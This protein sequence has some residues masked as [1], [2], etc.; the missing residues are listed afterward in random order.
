LPTLTTCEGN[1]V[2]I[3]GQTTDVPGIYTL[4]L[5]NINGCDSIISQ[6]LKV[7]PTTIEETVAFCEGTSKTVFDSTFT[8]TGVICKTEVS[9]ITG[10][11]VTTCVT[12]KEVPS[13]QVPEQDSALVIALNGEVV[14]DT[15]NDYATYEWI[16]FNPDILSCPDC[17]DPVAS[18][19]TSTK[20][21]L[22]ITD[23]NGCR[24]TAEYRVFVCD[25]TKIY[26]PNAFTPN[27]DGANDLFRVVPHEGADVILSLRV[28][29]R[30]GQKLYE[31]SGPNAQWDGRI[32]D[33]LAPSDVYVWVLDYEC[34]GERHRESK[35]VTLL[36]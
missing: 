23:G 1:P 31:G 14:I 5:Q 20:F 12:V 10:C 34:G 26:I 36:R 19:D 32:G 24:D 22:V 27:G 28:Y 18:P 15:P 3:L 33:K 6:E 13:P 16:P 35:D 4:E 30:W 11:V 29:D 17:P 21:L 2:L 25:E 9:P 8:S 7:E